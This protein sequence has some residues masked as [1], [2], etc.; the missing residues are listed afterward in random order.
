[1]DWLKECEKSIIDSR[2]TSKLLCDWC[3]HVTWPTYTYNH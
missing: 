1:M 3:N 2:E